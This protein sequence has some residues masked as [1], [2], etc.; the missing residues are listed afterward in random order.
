VKELTIHRKLSWFPTALAVVVMLVLWSAPALA[1]CAMCK[2]ALANSAEG[3]A[4]AKQFN[5]AILV[6]LLPP[7]VMFF[8]IFGMIYRSGKKD[9]R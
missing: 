6:L 3:A 5:L 7:V 4:T 2:E 9:P 8:G 1:Q